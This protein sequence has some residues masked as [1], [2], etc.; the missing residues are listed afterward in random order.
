MSNILIINGTQP[1]E[2]APGELNAA[3]VERTKAQLEARGHNVQVTKVVD[4]YDVDEE[5]SHHQWADTVIF[6]FPINWMGVPWVLKKYLDEV[7]T[8]GMD[9]R[10]ATGDGRSSDAPTKNYGM[11][12][13]LTGKKYML[14]VTFNAPKEAFDDPSEP[15]FK[16]GSVDDLLRPMH[17][18]AEFVAMSAL[19]TFASFDV[20]KNPQIEADF[21][22]F[23]AHLKE[24]FPKTEAVPA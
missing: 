5:I 15:L 11:G 13:T 12:G 21:T 8:A 1:Y 17:L 23:D 7:Y 20:M 2:F 9:G 16:G 22:R 6:Q 3:F 24:A 10:M 19:P 18:T 4:G 14:S